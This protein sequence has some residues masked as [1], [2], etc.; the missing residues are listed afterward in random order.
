MKNSKNILLNKWTKK[1]EKN[2]GETSYNPACIL[3]IFPLILLCFQRCCPNIYG[4]LTKKRTKIAITNRTSEMLVLG[5][6]WVQPKFGKQKKKAFSRWRR[7]R[8][9]VRR[10]KGKKTCCF[11]LDREEGEER[12]RDKVEGER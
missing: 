2:C 6:W 8:K 5:P 7:E 9:K 1:M 12:Q 3:L 4:K 11:V 10:R